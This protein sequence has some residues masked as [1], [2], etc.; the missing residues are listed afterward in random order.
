MRI[1]V[2]TL[3]SLIATLFIK[4]DGRFQIVVTIEIDPFDPLAA[5]VGFLRIEQQVGDVVAACGRLYVKSLALAGARYGF[6][7]AQRHAAH[8]LV[9]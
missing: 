6:Q 2:V 5:R 8:C 1:I 9:T 4:R 7:L 3:T